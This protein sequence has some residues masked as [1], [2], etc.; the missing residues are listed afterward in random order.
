MVL[1]AYFALFVMT[2]EGANCV[3]ELLDME[4]RR[5]E[6][7]DVARVDVEAPLVEAVVE[8]TDETDESLSW[9][10]DSAERY[11]AGTGELGAVVIVPDV[12]GYN[13]WS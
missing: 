5:E 10:T 13:E 12:E 1:R 7:T 6:G 4:E 8:S 2:G 3:T 9:E 11:E